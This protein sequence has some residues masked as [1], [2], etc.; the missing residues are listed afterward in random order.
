MAEQPPPEMKLP[1]PAEMT[2]A[3]AKI[4]ERSERLVTEFL[5]RQQ[6]QRGKA[7]QEFDPQNLD[8]LNIGGAFL[9][10]EP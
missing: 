7:S 4:A 9:E 6:T 3:M 1:D 8:P 10:N 5:E 2:R